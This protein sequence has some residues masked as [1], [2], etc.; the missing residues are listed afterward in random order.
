MIFFYSCSLFSVHR[1]CYLAVLFRCSPGCSFTTFLVQL[2]PQLFPGHVP[3]SVVHPVVARPRSLSS[4]SPS[5]SQ[6]TFLVLLFTQLFPGHVPCSVVHLVVPRPRS[7]T[8]SHPLPFS[9]QP[10]GPTCPGPASL[11]SPTPPS[12][13]G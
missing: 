11:S 13:P 7:S 3:C 12:S 8:P 4:F 10:V 6:T 1:A 2:F 5:C 9:G